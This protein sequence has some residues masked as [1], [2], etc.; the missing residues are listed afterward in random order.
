[1]GVNTDLLAKTS[2]ANG[3]R[4]VIVDMYT[5]RIGLLLIKRKVVGSSQPFKAMSQVGI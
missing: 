2:M 5:Y 1:M 3:F 4:H